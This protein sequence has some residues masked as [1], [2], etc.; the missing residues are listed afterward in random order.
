MPINNF[1]TPE[2]DLENQTYITESWL[3]DQWIGD[4]L[5]V[6]GDNTSGQ[7]G[8]NLISSSRSTPITTLPGGNNWKQISCGESHSAAIKTDG[9]LWTWG[10]NSYGQL[11][12]NLGTGAGT[13][14]RSTPV[15][16]F[17]GGTNWKQVS[18]GRLFTTAIKTD[19]TLWTWGR[20][21]FGQLGTNNSVDRS[22][23]VTTFT[24]G[25]NWKQISGGFNHT[26]AVKTDG[27]LWGWGRN[28]YAQL[29]VN[30]TTDRFSPVETSAAGTNWKQVA[31]GSEF[32]AAIK[33]DGTLWAWGNGTAGILGNN[34]F[35]NR[36]TPVTTFAGNTNWKQVSCGIL[37]M[38]AIKTD[39]TLWAWG[40]NFS[41]MLGIN[42]NNPGG[43][44]TPVTTFSGGNNWKQ[45]SC[46][47]N[48]SAA[49]KTDGTLWLWGQNNT[50]Q[51][52]N[53]NTVNRSTPVTTFAGGNNWKQ[54]S[55]GQGHTM[56]VTSGPE[57]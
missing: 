30:D 52:G 15:T 11:G 7:L 35:N 10:L 51:L 23:P 42:D 55:T 8:Q 22:T 38:A 19:G 12:N 56:V 27:T 32:T 17:A 1:R 24:G 39:G 18:C 53:G 3:V 46:G 37:H 13:A 49:I 34:Q 33:T 28:S 57:Y 36:S 54:V 25:N 5:W 6:W 45:V 41:G 14:N 26:A 21:Q 43:I 4:Q 31:C 48:F 20:N 47:T 9:T 29:G 50:G 16:T 44:L 2:G 40:S